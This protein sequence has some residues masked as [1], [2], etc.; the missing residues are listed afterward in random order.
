MVHSTL[1]AAALFLIADIAAR[2]RGSFGD[3]AQPGPDFAG[4]GKVALL[5]MVAAIAATGLPPL[6]GFIGKLLIL[7][8]A[9]G[10]SGWGWVWSVIL[11]TT[12]IGVIG[13]ARMGSAVFWKARADGEAPAQPVPRA[14][15]VP[16]IC[17]LVLLAALSAG[18]GWATAY[19]DETAWQV[20]EPRESAAVVLTGEAAR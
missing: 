17:A 14:D 12:F 7:M 9:G 11:A 3:T 19:A 10:K 2:R 1:A 8:T 4:R 16:A 18:A 13:F 5:F 20:L 6:S 15:M